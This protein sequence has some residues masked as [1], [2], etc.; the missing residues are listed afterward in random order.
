[1]AFSLVGLPTESIIVAMYG[2]S[3]TNHTVTFKLQGGDQRVT[4]VFE[5][6]T[7]NLE[8]L[9]AHLDARFRHNLTF[10]ERRG[11]PFVLEV[12]CHYKVRWAVP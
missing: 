7:L 10:L 5:V 1:M 12:A 11:I 6:E 8:A 9:I 4:I 3:G 2:R